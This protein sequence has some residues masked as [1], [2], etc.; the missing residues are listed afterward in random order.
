[1]SEILH[2]NGYCGEAVEVLSSIP[3]D[4]IS[5]RVVRDVF[6]PGK[7]PDLGE[8]ISD[9]SSGEPRTKFTV[10]NT[11][12]SPNFPPLWKRVFWEQ[13]IGNIHQVFVMG[14]V[15]AGK[16]IR[17]VRGEETVFEMPIIPHAA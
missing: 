3:R 15:Q 8:V 9:C 12:P 16:Q 7:R 6:I 17:G 4:N 2:Y 5:G 10:I 11:S 13:D 1:M 14:H